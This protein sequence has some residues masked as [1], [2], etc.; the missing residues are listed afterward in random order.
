MNLFIDTNI[1]LSFYHLTSDDLEELKKLSVLIDKE[2]ITLFITD[3]VIDEFNRNRE[4]KIADAVKRLKEQKLNLQFPQLCKDYEEYEK[5]RKLQKEYEIEHANLLNKIS[6]DVNENRTKADK[7]IKKL[8]LK[9]EKIERT[10]EL[11]ERAQIRG[12]IGNPPGK[13]GSLGDSIN[14]ESLLEKI[15]SGEDLYFITDDKDYYS[16][17][18]ENKTKE[19]LIKEWENNKISSI[20]IYRQLSRFFKEFFPDIKLAS[21]IEKELLI[22]QIVSSKNFATTHNAISGLSQYEVF[23]EP[24]VNS[25]IQATILNTQIR[26]ILDD[27]DVKTFIYRLVKTHKSII[28]KNSLAEL[29]EILFPDKE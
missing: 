8:Y 24:E 20:F 12:E 17:L 9:C 21:E 29:K 2:E 18:N 14:W 16:E 23:S 7:I 26:W 15:P 28:D 22:N 1:F 6:T 4:S 11:I 5:L 3:Q 10:Q 19:F 13:K 27:E 25:I